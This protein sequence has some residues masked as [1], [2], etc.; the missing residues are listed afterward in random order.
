MTRRMQENLLRGKLDR[1][2]LAKGKTKV[3]AL[4]D[5]DAPDLTEFAVDV[6]MPPALTEPMLQ[7]A[8]A[9]LARAH[10][11]AVIRDAETPIEPGD[12]VLVDLVGYANGRVVPG[13]AKPQV[14]LTEEDEPALPGV[15]AVL[16]GQTVGKS[17]WAKVKYP[18]D[19]P[20][21]FLA[22]QQLVYAVDVLGARAVQ[23][24]ELDK[25]ELLQAA[26][27]ED[28]DGLLGLLAEGLEAE[29]EQTALRYVQ[30]AVADALQEKLGPV[31][32]GDD[33]IDAE[34]EQR[35]NISE[36]EFLREKGLSVD[37]QAY[38]R[39]A[40]VKDPSRRAE[41]VHGLR[42]TMA[43]AAIAKE[44]DLRPTREELDMWVE[45][46]ASLEGRP[47]DEVFAE[48]KADTETHEAVGQALLLEKAFIWVLEHATITWIED[49][50]SF[51]SSP[52]D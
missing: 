23:A 26:G 17:V 41:L 9:E 34:L 18:E 51:S 14:W 12:E 29:R 38:A 10:G 8:A 35:W 47:K 5:V 48:L 30:L 24:A 4:P 11:E 50:A 44:K 6:P 33:I 36:G 31:E 46:V 43:L 3:D 1:A 37:D 40:F 20:I 27:V 25:P 49:A 52:S 42:T 16:N 39:D 28:L 32:I 15:R 45:H 13:S 21:P 2:P 19:A 22:G 7:A